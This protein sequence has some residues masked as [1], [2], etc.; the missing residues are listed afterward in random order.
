MRLRRSAEVPVTAGVSGIV[1]VLAVFNFG[2]VDT[3]R[4]ELIIFGV[5][6]L[7]YVVES[8]WYALTGRPRG[9]LRG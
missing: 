3:W 1:F 2:G 6:G 5:W 8:C 9:V 7:M 4:N